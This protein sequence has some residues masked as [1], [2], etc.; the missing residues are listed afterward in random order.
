MQTNQQGRT[1]TILAFPTAARRAAANLGNKAKFSAELA[2][3]KDRTVDIDGWYHQTAIE[4]E[5]GK[6]HN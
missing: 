5:T 2:A 6:P 1:A 4:D 3:L